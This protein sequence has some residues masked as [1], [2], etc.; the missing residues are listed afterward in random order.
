MLRM[1]EVI[2]AVK[3]AVIIET[4]VFQG[5]SMIYYAS[6]LEAMGQGRV[7][8]IDIEIPEFVRNNIAAH[9]L[10]SRITL[11]EGSSVDAAIFEKVKSLAAGEAPVMVILDS[12]HSKKHVAA[13]L[14]LYAPL[15]T[16]G[17][18]IVATDGVMKDIADVPRALADWKH[19]NPYEA[20]NEFAARHAEFVRGQPAWPV[21]DSVL[22][23]NITYWP[24]A[25]FRRS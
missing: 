10:S 11:L 17:S 18:Y 23:E 9:P 2:Y 3:P 19:D 21:H 12:D 4:G 14:E 8:G 20:A 24:G 25:W 5:G 15:V 1:Q 6:L 7:I 22:T 16:P 13:E